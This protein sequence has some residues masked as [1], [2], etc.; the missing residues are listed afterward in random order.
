MQLRRITGIHTHKP[1]TQMKR[2]LWVTRDNHW[3]LIRASA[4]LRLHAQRVTGTAP[5]ANAN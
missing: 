3:V 2:Y 4:S 5:Y 1:A